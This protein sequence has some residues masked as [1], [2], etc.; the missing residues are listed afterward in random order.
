MK[1]IVVGSGAGG[2]TATR[3]LVTSGHEVLVLEAGRRF[4]PFTR[5]IELANGLRGA[6]LLGGEETINHIFPHINT[7]RSSDDLVL[8]RGVTTGGSTMISCGNAVRAE[9]GL[10]EIGLDLSPEYRGIEE[11][12]KPTPIPRSMWRPVTQRMFDSAENLGLEPTPTQKMVDISKCV[13]CGLCELGCK[14]GARWSA[15]R[16]FPK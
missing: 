8:V 11:L 16:F 15:M 12:L 5:H 9:N 13:S 2:A 4:Q 7:L 1:V 14:T 10:K 6:G 3:E